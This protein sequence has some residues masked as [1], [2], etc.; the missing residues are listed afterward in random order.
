[1]DHSI[2]EGGPPLETTFTSPG[3]YDRPH[4]N[5]YDV[6]IKS[7]RCNQKSRGW[8]P[9][10][11]L[12]P[13]P[14]TTVSIILVL[15]QGILYQNYSNDPIFPARDTYVL[16]P[17]ERR[18]YLNWQNAATVMACKDWNGW[19]DPSISKDWLNIS[20]PIEHL[21]T[22][23]QTLAGAKIIVWALMG[24]SIFSAFNFRPA[25][26]LEAQSLVYHSSPWPM[27][28]VGRETSISAPLATE[29]WRVEA[30]LLFRASIARMHLEV[31]NMAFG[32]P[33]SWPYYER[34]AGTEKLCD[35]MY[36]FNAIG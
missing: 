29:Q 34:I 31:R 24:S 22:D 15:S 21:F 12:Q 3:H 16:H 14:G 18:F 33:K 8:V 13:D 28:G 17:I 4:L 6:E 7:T 25:A 9:I 11:G 35:K 36:L 20:D 19:R 32:V 23:K 10:D 5:N 27:F 2:F 26:S 1:M 30:E